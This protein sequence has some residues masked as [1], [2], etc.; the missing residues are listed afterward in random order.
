MYSPAIRTNIVASESVSAAYFFIYLDSRKREESSGA[1]IV[2]VSYAK[3]FCKI[4]DDSL[5]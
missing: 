1:K 4:T 2:A 5:N 3:V